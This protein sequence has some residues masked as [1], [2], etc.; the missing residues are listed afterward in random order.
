MGNPKHVHDKNIQL[1]AEIFNDKKVYKQMFFSVITKSLNCEIL[2]KNL[3]TLKD[4]MRLR[5][6]NFNILRVH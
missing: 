4:N 1:K 5:M 6:K 3:A 2:T